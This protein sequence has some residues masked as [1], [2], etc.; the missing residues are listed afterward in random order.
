MPGLFDDILKRAALRKAQAAALA[1]TGA[2]VRL[3]HADGRTALAGPDMSVT[4]R[5]RL[6]QFDAAGPVGHTEHISLADAILEGLRNHYK[7]EKE[8]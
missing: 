7:P 1:A 2:S 5:W 8:L 3:R 4:G 6:T